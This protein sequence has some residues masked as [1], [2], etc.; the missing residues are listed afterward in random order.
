MF[1]NLTYSWRNVKRFGYL[2][3]NKSEI[4]QQQ[5]T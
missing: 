3:E 2:E 1:S 5:N 4:L